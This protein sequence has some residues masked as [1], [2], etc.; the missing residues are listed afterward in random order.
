MLYDCE[1]V[2]NISYMNCQICFIAKKDLS[3]GSSNTN[4]E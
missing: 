3:P 1:Y 4:L 2:K